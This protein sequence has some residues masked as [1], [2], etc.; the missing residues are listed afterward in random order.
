VTEKACLLSVGLAVYNGELYLEEAIQSLLGQTFKDFE[1]IISDNA[2]TDR[3]AEI[4]KKYAA[5]DAR[6]RYIRNPVNIGGANNENSTFR[7]SRGQYFR[8]AAHDDV[9]EPQ[10]FEKCIE[11]LQA[12]RD[13]V[14]CYSQCV[15][16]DELGRRVKLISRNHAQSTDA[17]KRFE[18]L[19]LAKDFCE[20]TYG[21]IRSDVLAKTRL[22][23]NYTGSDRTLLS[24]LALYGPFHEVQEPLFL[25]RFHEK[26]RYSDWRARMVWFND[27]AAGKITLPFWMQFFDYLETIRRVPLTRKDKMRCYLVMIKWIG[28]FGKNMAKDIL[29]AAYMLVHSKKW[30]RERHEQARI[31]D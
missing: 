21:I 27:D 2:S 20:E 11:V 9:C 31:W 19:C 17:P 10:L 4:C 1:L 12:R 23:Q 16:I 25:K 8:L 18:A 30:R 15:E 3:T 6:I 14:L 13:I 5:M 22:Q 28:V 29:V 7:M 24:E 26:N